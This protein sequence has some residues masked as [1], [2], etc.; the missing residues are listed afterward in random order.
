MQ[1]PYN[2]LH[3]IVYITI[4]L[5]SYYNEL[6]SLPQDVLSAKSISSFKQ[7]LQQ[8]GG[9]KTNPLYCF[10]H[11]YEKLTHTRLRL[12]LSNLTEHVFD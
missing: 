9:Q 10:G 6:N 3:V 1:V 12:G 7:I 2:P 5:C 4:L 8:T 11:G